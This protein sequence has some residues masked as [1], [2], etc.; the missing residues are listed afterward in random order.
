MSLEEMDEIW[1]KA[2]EE[3]MKKDFAYGIIVFF[4]ENENSLFSYLK[5]GTGSLVVPKRS[6]R[7]G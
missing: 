7:E 1:N 4:V 6:C 3:Y 2:K 5:T